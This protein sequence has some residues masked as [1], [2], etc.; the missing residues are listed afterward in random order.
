MRK[1]ASSSPACGRSCFDR[2]RAEG[3]PLPRSGRAVPHR[4]LGRCPARPV[5]PED[6]SPSGPVRELDRRDGIGALVF[7]E[8][9]PFQE[10]QGVVGLEAARERSGWPVVGE[11][12]VPLVRVARIRQSEADRHDSSSIFQ[13]ARRPLVESAFDRPRSQA[14]SL[15]RSFPRQGR[16]SGPDP[17]LRPL[18]SPYRIERSLRACPIPVSISRRWPVS[19]RRPRITAGLERS[20]IPGTGRNRELDWRGTIVEV[21]FMQAELD[22][23]DR[24]PTSTTATLPSGARDEENEH[25]VIGR[26]IRRLRISD[27]PQHSK[28][29]PTCCGPRSRWRPWHGFPGT[30]AIR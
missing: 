23:N 3:P 24:R 14:R 12:L 13:S 8:T 10:R 2:G 29:A 26:L 17:Y 20:A 1:P 4:D 5:A 19:N 27:S 25:A 21:I 11:D 28:L 16:R 9:E 22:G 30:R 18:V 15:M 7:A 6:V